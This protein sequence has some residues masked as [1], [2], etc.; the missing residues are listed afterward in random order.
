MAGTNSAP[1]FDYRIS[2]PHGHTLAWVEAKRRFGTDDEWAKAWR[3]HVLEYFP[4]SD[5]R[6]LLVLPDR[7]YGWGESDPDALPSFSMDARP[8][9]APYFERLGI[10]PEN[11]RPMA[12]EMLVSW[13]LSDLLNDAV[14]IEPSEVARQ[15]LP[16]ARAGSMVMSSERR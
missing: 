5:E 10:E 11:I 14:G 1:G 2:D 8:V 15:V 6:L 7:V 12:F 13:W 3:R 4:S 9:L 16:D